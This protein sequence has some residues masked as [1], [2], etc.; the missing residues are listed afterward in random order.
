M[1]H[2]RKDASLSLLD[3]LVLPAALPVKGFFLVAG[4]I[5]DL[6]NREVADDSTIRKRLAELQVRYEAGEVSDE[7]YQA[8]WAG[9]VAR[10]RAIEEAR[11]RTTGG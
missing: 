3:L 8:A 1:E 11:R 2:V 5:R 6:A 10:L 9:L 7:E 4:A